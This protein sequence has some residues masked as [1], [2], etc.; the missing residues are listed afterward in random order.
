MKNINKGLRPIQ[1][2]RIIVFLLVLYAGFFL[3]SPAAQAF[4]FTTFD[5]PGSVSTGAFGINPSGQIVRTFTD[6][7]F[8]GHGFLL[9]KKGNFTTFDPPGSISTQPNGISPSGQIVGFFE[10]SSFVEH[11]F[12]ASP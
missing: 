3:F 1:G 11:G 4:T 9:D 8:V 12:L 5:V 7:S 6:S 10:D 2:I